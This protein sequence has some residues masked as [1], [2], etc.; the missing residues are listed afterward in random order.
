MDVTKGKFYYQGNLETKD[1]PW[2]ISISY[3][4][5]GAPI[6]A[7]EL[8]GKSGHLEI[9]IKTSENKNC[10][11]TFFENYLLQA[12][13]VLNTELCFNIK[14][15][16]ATAGNVGK[17]RQ[18]LYNIMA[19]QEKDIKITADVEDFEMDGI[20]FKG[21]PIGF[22]IDKDSIDTSS[23]KDK[24]KEITDATKDLD[25]GAK[26]LKDGTADALEGSEK[27]SDGTS[28]LSDGTT[29]LLDGSG[30]LS[31]GSQSLLSGAS[32]LQSG[33]E[34]YTAGTVNLITGMKQYI[35]GTDQLAAGA[36]KLKALENLGQITTAVQ[37]LTAA[38]N[39]DGS[40]QDLTTGSAQLTEGLKGR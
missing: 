21:V 38:V 4:L 39:G 22:D 13:V 1:I 3:K 40:S 24:T 27:L 35:R 8:A 18:L 12:T 30:T 34:E 37:K 6:A 16:G 11:S 10:N 5:D 36:K 9:E 23:L 15:D 17:D 25:D 33:I 14:A 7:S 19:D 31:S 20:T 29:T 32:S 28:T 2:N 26:E